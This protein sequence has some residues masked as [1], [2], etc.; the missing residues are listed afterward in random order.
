MIKH[1]IKQWD[2]FK[3]E[4]EF[5]LDLEYDQSEDK[6]YWGMAYE[7]L[8]KKVF[9]LVV[10]QPREQTNWS[11]C[12][13]DW[14]R[15]QII[16]HGDYQGEMI[17]IMVP[18]T[19]QPS[20]FSDYYFTGVTYGSCSACDTMQWVQYE[21]KTKH[22]KIQALMNAALHIVQSTKTFQS[23]ILKR[24]VRIKVLEESCGFDPDAIDNEVE[25]RLAKT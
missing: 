21:L 20:L 17:F 23:H 2:E 24:E 1:F 19:Y 25:R 7:E 18:D 12:E 5:F 9:E 10:T 3:H 14:D 22:E 15:F 8:F 11:S 16:N 4:L 6:Q 13:W